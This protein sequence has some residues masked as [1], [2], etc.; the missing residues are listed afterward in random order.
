MLEQPET[1][2]RRRY[3]HNA[4]LD[5]WRDGLTSDDIAIALGMRDGAAVRTIMKTARRHGDPRAERRS[6][7]GV[8]WPSSLLDVDWW[9]SE[10][11]ARGVS[12]LALQRRVLK[13]AE[14]GL[15]AAILDDDEAPQ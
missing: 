9:R 10:A 3:D 7:G 2:R 4:A 8:K 15:L 1:G 13:L 12:V 6:R 5:M 14:D 11:S